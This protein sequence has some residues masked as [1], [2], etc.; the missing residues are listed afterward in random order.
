MLTW[1]RLKDH[2]LVIAVSCPPIALPAA[3]LLPSVARAV[4]LAMTLFVSG[5][6]YGAALASIDRVMVFNLMILRDALL[7]EIAIHIAIPA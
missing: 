5:G 7:A 1:F 2:R 4:V 6:D 3:I